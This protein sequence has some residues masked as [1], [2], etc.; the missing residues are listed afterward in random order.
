MN[1]M[2]GVYGVS[3]G[4]YH[5]GDSMSVSG[6]SPQA[7]KR[8]QG[9]VTEGEAARRPVPDQ[10]PHEGGG[11]YNHRPWLHRGPHGAALHRSWTTENAAS[12]SHAPIFRHHL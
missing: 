8:L 2:C 9:P 10:S 12:V 1:Q 4:C 6:G 7:L 11:G 3:A 5:E